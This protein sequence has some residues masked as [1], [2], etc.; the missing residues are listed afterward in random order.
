VWDVARALAV[1][2]LALLAL[3]LSTPADLDLPEMRPDDRVSG[4]ATRLT[5]RFFTVWRAA[6]F[7]GLPVVALAV[8]TL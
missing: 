4:V 5:P 2:W 8:M 3:K 1:A 6:Y 7:L